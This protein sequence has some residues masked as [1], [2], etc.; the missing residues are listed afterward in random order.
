M[1][2]VHEGNKNVQFEMKLTGI[3]NTP[4]ARITNEGVRI[5]NTKESE[6]MNSKKEF[7]GPSV[8]RK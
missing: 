7:F 5:K 6:L 8:R 1:K 2:I 3:F 4:L